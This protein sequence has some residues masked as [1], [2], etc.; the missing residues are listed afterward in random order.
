MTSGQSDNPIYIAIEIILVFP[1]S[2]HFLV[3]LATLK[4]LELSRGN[5]C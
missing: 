1:S 5:G 4:G 2:T 3:L